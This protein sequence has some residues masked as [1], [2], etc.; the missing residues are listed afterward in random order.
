MK[1]RERE[2]TMWTYT[3]DVSFMSQENMGIVVDTTG[4]WFWRRFGEGFFYVFLMSVASGSFFLGECVCACVLVFSQDG[5]VCVC[6]RVFR[7]MG[8]S[9]SPSVKC[10][11]MS[12]S[13]C[14]VCCVCVCV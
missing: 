3:L 7:R 12:A 4:L 1:E 13:V 5:R 8:C 14:I 9:V 11:P 6:L 10:N 2:R